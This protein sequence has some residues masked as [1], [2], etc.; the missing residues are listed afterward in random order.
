LNIDKSSRD[1]TR[2]AAV[3]PKKAYKAPSFRFE[4]VF[5]V[6]ALVCGKI[7]STQSSCR[8]NHKSS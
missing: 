1:K 5:E 8:L 7:Y 6:T 2:E 3:T 4:P